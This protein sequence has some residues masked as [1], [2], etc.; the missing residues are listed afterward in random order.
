MDLNTEKF[1]KRFDK[2]WQYQLLCV[3]SRSRSVASRVLPSFK[4]EYLE[5]HYDRLV[6]R[7][8]LGYHEQYNDV[9]TLASL[10]ALTQK[11]IFEEKIAASDGDVV[12]GF[13]EKIY[14][15][16]VSE[17][18]IQST[19]DGYLDFMRQQKIKSAIIKGAGLLLEHD[20]ESCED[21]IRKSFDEAFLFG[22]SFGELGTDFHDFPED[23]VKRGEKGL[24]PDVCIVNR[25]PKINQAVGNGFTR[26]GIYIFMAPPGFGK[27]TTLI[28]LGSSFLWS[29]YNVLHVTLEMKEQ[30]VADRYG[31]RMLN[32]KNWDGENWVKDKVA[33]L[34]KRFS[35]LR[36]IS[37]I[38]EKAGRLL[39]KEFPTR[40]LSISGLKSHMSLCEANGFNPDVLIVDYADLMKTKSREKRY[41]EL[42]ELYERLRG[43]GGEMNCTVLSASQTNRSGAV[44][45]RPS[46][47]DIAGSFGKF[48][49]ADAIIGLCQTKKEKACNLSRMY[50][51]KS[52][53]ADYPNAIWLKTDF[54]K[55]WMA[56]LEE[57]EVPTEFINKEVVSDDKEMSDV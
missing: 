46:M 22:H 50:V 32:R 2:N 44:K 11:E 14:N 48:G 17:A 9:P 47:N 21:E 20:I 33:A 31:N 19:L 49:A 30:R 57:S 36:T 27:T 10:L 52:R 28:N 55:C 5:Q 45:Y 23:L 7:L 6:C 43:L 8:L 26:G 1:Q 42:E 39:I 40:S 34:Y 25:Y 18:T 15:E 37:G 12:L 38:F 56:E 24:N 13:I 3:I 16:P 51:L 54:S 53:E 29:G 41:E 4:P 35:H